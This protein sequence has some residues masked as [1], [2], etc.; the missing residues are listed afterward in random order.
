MLVKRSPRH[1][2]LIHSDL[3]NSPRRP[4]CR[5]ISLY[6]VDLDHSG[7]FTEESTVGFA[8]RL[9][10]SPTQK[11]ANSSIWI[12]AEGYSSSLFVE[13]TISKAIDRPHKI[14]LLGFVSPIYGSGLNLSFEQI[15]A[16]L[17]AS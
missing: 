11:T 1:W 9:C 15:T 7:E 5:R 16:L 3:A 2:S 10:G 6:K 14:S 13:K 17:K 8:N 4:K 12:D